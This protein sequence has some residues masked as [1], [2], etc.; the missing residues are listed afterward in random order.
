MGLQLTKAG[1]LAMAANLILEGDTPDNQ[2]WLFG[3]SIALFTNDLVPT[4][5]TAYADL[6]LPTWTGYS[7]VAL[8][9]TGPYLTVVN[10]GL[11]TAQLVTFSPTATPAE[12]VNVYGY[13]IFLPGS[14][15]V[16]YALEKWTTPQIV[17]ADESVV[18]FVPQV[19]L[20][21]SQVYG[22]SVVI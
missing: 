1:M 8:T 20:P 18:R 15:N 11:L 13:G 2:G 12:A 9:W 7:P 3:T 21:I 6:T 4:P 5:I 14:P 17:T 19:L 16:L 22:G 10:E